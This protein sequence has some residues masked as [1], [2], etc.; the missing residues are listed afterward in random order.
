MADNGGSVPGTAE[1]R[2][3]PETEK[4]MELLETKVENVEEET[5]EDDDMP[6]DLIL[7]EENEQQQMNNEMNS[8]NPVIQGTGDILLTLHFNFAF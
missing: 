7:K 4:V 1:I 3:V 8:N 6:L 5:I 2:E